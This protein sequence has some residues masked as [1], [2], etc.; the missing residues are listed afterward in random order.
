MGHAC[1]VYR[2]A[3]PTQ[4]EQEKA[5]LKVFLSSST[6]IL[7]IVT[8][9]GAILVVAVWSVIMMNKSHK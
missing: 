8:I 5:M 2:T 9:V 6:G 3:Y 1:P 4:L 7:S